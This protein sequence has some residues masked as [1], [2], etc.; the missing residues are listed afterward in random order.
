MRQDL[1]KRLYSISLKARI[2]KSWQ[3][4]NQVGHSP[5]SEREMLVLEFVHEFSKYAP[6]TESVVC[7]VLGISPSSSSDLVGK[8]VK[9]DYLIKETGDKG[10]TRNKPL[11]TTKEGLQFLE[12]RVRKSGAA[13]FAYLFSGFTKEAEWNT[14]GD[15]VES[16]DE[17]ATKAVRK[18]VFGQYEV[19]FE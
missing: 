9:L 16:V 4:T 12:E 7:K 11:Q 15:I 8:L 14:L 17:A 19:D 1:L 18:F 3:E 5:L 10:Q 13:R 6:V 2:L